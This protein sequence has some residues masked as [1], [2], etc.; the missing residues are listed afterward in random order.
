MALQGDG[1]IVA[2]GAAELDGYSFALARYNPDGSLDTSFSGDGQLTTNF[3]GVGGGFDA[4]NG[5]ALQGD[6]KIVA[7]GY[8]FGAGAAFA[9]ARYNPDGSLDT[10]FSGDGMQR[11]D[12]GDD[13][14][15]NGVALQGDGKIVAAGAA[16]FDHFALARYNTDG[17]LDTS[18]SGDGQL[19]TDVGGHANGVALQGDGKIVA[20]GGGGAGGADFALARYNADG[21]LDT[22][23]SGDGLQTTDFAGFDRANGMALQG[24]GKIVVVGH[25]VSAGIDDSD[26]AL[27]RYLGG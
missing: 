10:S 3:G 6:G 27:A 9:L 8:S 5:V 18:F 24:D 13:G 15:A 26:F 21:S 25:S 23:F 12:V 1:K 14:Q 4:A 16:G 19:T 20:A 2:V 22:S 11:T 7:V 17:S